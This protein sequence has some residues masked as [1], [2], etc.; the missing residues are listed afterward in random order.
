MRISPEVRTRCIH[1][2][3][4]LIVNTASLVN[5]H[6]ERIRL[7]PMNRLHEP[8][9]HTRGRDTFSTIERYPFEARSGR[10]RDAIVELAVIG[11]VPDMAEHVE[12][13]RRMMGREV[14]E[15]TWTA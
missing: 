3:T 15:T 8:Y 1:A 4:V 14:L 13:V 12:M 5:A 2:H 7:C 6:A 9:P 10:G 11:G